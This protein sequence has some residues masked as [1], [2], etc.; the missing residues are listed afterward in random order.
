MPYRPEELGEPSSADR[1]AAEILDEQIMRAMAARGY[2]GAGEFEFQLD[3][4]LEEGVLRALERLYRGHGWLI[5]AAVEPRWSAAGKFEVE[6]PVLVIQPDPDAGRRSRSP[7][8]PWLP[9]P[10]FPGLKGL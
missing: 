1:R 8:S 10:P 3:A 4:A 7:W 6:V 5:R 2:A 9:F